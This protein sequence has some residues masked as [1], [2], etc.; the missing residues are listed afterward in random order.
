MEKH[1]FRSSKSKGH[2]E[3]V[4]L[5]GCFV[6][7]S[8]YSVL[9]STRGKPGPW[10]WPSLLLK[11]SPRETPRLHLP[12]APLT[13]AVGQWF[14]QGVLSGEVL[15]LCLE[16]T[17]ILLATLSRSP[18][19]ECLP[20]PATANKPLQAFFFWGGFTLTAIAAKNLEPFFDSSHL[21]P[22]LGP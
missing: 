16:G 6:P 21:R 20:V 13:V 1:N 15:S 9:E 12:V 22:K 5:G 4:F 2:F 19:G 11:V 8:K 7:L 17:L 14:F 3:V 18:F 10:P